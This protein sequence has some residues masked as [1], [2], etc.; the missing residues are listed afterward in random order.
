MVMPT[1]A[2]R[3]TPA[4]PALF[5]MAAPLDCVGVAEVEEVEVTALDEVGLPVEV[6]AGVLRGVVEEPD[7][8]GERGAVDCPAICERI[9]A[10]KTPVIPVNSNLAEKA[11]AGN[12]GCA[13]SFNSRDS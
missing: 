5:A 3:R 11:R 8:V 2:L 13:A 9:S 12:W 6:V 4:Q 7:D 10:E 1:R